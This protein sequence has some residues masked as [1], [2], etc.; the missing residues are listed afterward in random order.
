MGRG[1]VKFSPRP[2][3]WSDAMKRSWTEDFQYD[4]GN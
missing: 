3:D 1:N 4:D 2:I